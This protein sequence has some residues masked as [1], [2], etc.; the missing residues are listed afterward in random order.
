MQRRQ[1]LNI[2]LGTVVVGLAPTQIL[3]TD[4]R[5]AL[6]DVW[7]ATKVDAAIK[8]L[9]G[10]NNTIKSDQIKVKAPKVASNGGSI[11]ID[12]SAEMPIKSIAILQDANPE[13]TV[14][15]F[16]SNKYSVNEYGI[17]IKMS[18]S[19]TITAVAM[20]QDGKIYTNDITIE[21]ALGGCEG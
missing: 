1:F 18:K 21:V 2:A 7:S 5:K 16:E 12:I 14:A 13:A 17:K 4:L 11:P 8:A 6:P 3:A 15:V 9:Y 19:G 20:G 10:T